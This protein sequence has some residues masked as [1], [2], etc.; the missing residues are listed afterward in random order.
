ME[1]RAKITAF[2]FIYAEA[3][4]IHLES[5]ARVGFFYSANASFYDSVN[6]T[7]TA[8]DNLIFLQ[9]W[10][11]KY[12]HYVPQLAKLIVQSGLQFNLKGIAIG[13]PS[14]DF[15]I[16]SNAR[17]DYYWSHGLISD[18][19]HPLLTSVCNTS[20]LLREATI[21]GSLS[22]VCAA[23]AVQFTKE[24]SDSI[25]GYDVT[26]DVCVPEG[27]SKLKLHNNLLRPDFLVSLSTQL[28]QKELNH[29]AKAPENIDVCASKGF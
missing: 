18:S 20:Q 19:T 24:L 29:H 16:D 13:N 17:G 6:D 10:F 1:S 11:K 25:N 27:N 23:V 9:K 26:A 15:S 21:I 8:Q 3:N 22:P 7:I 14:L 28:L 4:I 12:R 2:L 5:P